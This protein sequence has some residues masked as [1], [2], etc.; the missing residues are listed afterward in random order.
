[1]RLL[2]RNFQCKT[3][4]FNDQQTWRVVPP[5][6]MLPPPSSTLIV[7]PHLLG[8]PSCVGLT[9][10]SK[11]SRQ[12]SLLSNLAV[13]TLA[14]LHFAAVPPE[15]LLPPPASTFIVTLILS[16]VQCTLRRPAVR[17]T[18]S[19]PSNLEAHRLLSI[20]HPAPSFVALFFYLAF[21]HCTLRPIPWQDTRPV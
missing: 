2:Q 19:R 8:I 17:S 16:A 20:A 7:N 6:L 15:L 14:S 21:C 13:E 1:M 10:L 5:E 3:L 12:T 11:P 9:S 18:L 4:K